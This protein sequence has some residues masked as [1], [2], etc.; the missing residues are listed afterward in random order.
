MVPTP[1]PLLKTYQMVLGCAVQGLTVVAGTLLAAAT[2]SEWGLV[3]SNVQEWGV[4]YHSGVQCKVP[5]R[6]GV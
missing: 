1:D 4:K 3:Q 5:F 2:S 6:S